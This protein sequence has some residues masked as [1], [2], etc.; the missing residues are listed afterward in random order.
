MILRYFL[1]WPHVYG[2]WSFKWYHILKKSNQG[3]NPLALAKMAVILLSFIAT[4]LSLVSGAANEQNCG[5]VSTIALRTTKLNCKIYCWSFSTQMLHF[6]VEYGCDLL[7]FL[8]RMEVHRK[9]SLAGLLTKTCF[10]SFPYLSFR[11][12]SYE[13]GWPGWLGYRDEFCLGFIWEILARCHSVLGIPA[14]WASPFPY[15]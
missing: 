3:N 6:Q 15:P 1:E 10:Y 5:K 12:S 9:T 7:W 11:A 14:F 8:A 4:S 13:P 2:K